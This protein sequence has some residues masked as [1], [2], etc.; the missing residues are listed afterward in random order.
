MRKSFRLVLVLVVLGMGFKAGAMPVIEANNPKAKA[1]YKKLDAEGYKRSHKGAIAA[2]LAVL[3]STIT[4]GV[5]KDWLDL[6]KISQECIK[7]KFGAKASSMLRQAE[8]A[9]TEANVSQ[10]K[11]IGAQAESVVVDYSQTGLAFYRGE[12]KNL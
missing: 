7:D 6:V 4:A 2:Y 1:L 3:L 8:A 9:V 5:D 10:A 12:C 11:S